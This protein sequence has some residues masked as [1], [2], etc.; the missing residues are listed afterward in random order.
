MSIGLMNVTNQQYLIDNTTPDEYL[1]I[2]TL[3]QEENRDNTLL[4]KI[5][6]DTMEERLNRDKI[7]VSVIQVGK[8]KCVDPNHLAKIWRIDHNV[9]KKTIDITTQ[10]SV[11]KYDPKLSR[12]YSTN[13]RMLRYKHLKEYFCMDMLFATKTS[14]WILGQTKK[15]KVSTTITR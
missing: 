8:H 11:R 7:M 5:Y 9:A 4:N 1:S 6:V 10:R 14:K 15:T 13:D 3:P 2:Q 12:N